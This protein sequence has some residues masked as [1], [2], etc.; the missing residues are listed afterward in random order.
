MFQDGTDLEPR[1]LQPLISIST[2]SPTTPIAKVSLV[3][4][5]G[6]HGKNVSY[7]YGY[8]P[9]ASV[10]L[11]GVGREGQ[12]LFKLFLGYSREKPQGLKQG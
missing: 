2:V 1:N 4:A 10:S 12:R 7:N 3:N 9:L 6:F 8:C 11:S 5:N